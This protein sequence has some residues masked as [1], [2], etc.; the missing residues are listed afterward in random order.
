MASTSQMSSV[1]HPEHES[2]LLAIMHGFCP[3][4]EVTSVAQ[5]FSGILS[6][7]V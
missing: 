7:P 3:A 2:Q 5:A 6:I 4:L 1:I